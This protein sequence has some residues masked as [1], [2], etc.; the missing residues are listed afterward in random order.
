MHGKAAHVLDDESCVAAAKA[1]DGA[2]PAVRVGER[3]AESAVAA[4]ER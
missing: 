2:A 3:R 4:V 1:V